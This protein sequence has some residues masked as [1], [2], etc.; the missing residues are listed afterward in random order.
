MY[1]GITATNSS[2]YYH[3]VTIKCKATFDVY[4]ILMLLLTV[5]METTEIVPD[6]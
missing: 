3:I 5:S 1:L 4:L 6:L 2:N